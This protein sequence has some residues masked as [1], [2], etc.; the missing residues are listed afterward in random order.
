VLKNMNDFDF[1]SSLYD[2]D[3][4]IL[5]GLNKEQIKAV[6]M[7][8]GPLLIQAGAGSG[9]TKTLTHRVAYI[10]SQ[11]KARSDE[12]LAV[13]F[14]NKAAQE[15]RQRV[16]RLLNENS[17]NRYFMPYMGT[18]HAIC[19]KLLRLEAELIGMSRSFV[20]F[21][22]ADRLA[23]VKRVIKELKIDEKTFSPKSIA[24][25]ISSAKNELL[26]AD[27]YLA[28]VNS[29]LTEVA[30]RV[31]PLYTK[32]LRQANGF[33]FDDL[34]NEVVRLFNTNTLVR[35]KWQQHFKYIMV[36]EYQD[37]NEAQYRLIRLL[38]NDQQNLAVIGDDWQTIFSW[39]G[40]NYR[41]ILNFE[42]DYPNCHVI[43]LEQN[44]RST[45]NI[46]AAGQAVITKNVDRSDKKLW[47]NSSDGLPVQVLQI[48]DERAE[49][50]TI[51]LKI[52]NDVSSQTRNY[53][54]FAILYRTNSQSRSLEESLIRYGLPYKVVGGQRFYDRKE[55]K[56]IIAYLRLIYQ[57]D[58]FISFD[59]IYNVPSRGIGRKSYSLFTQ[60]LRDNQFSL[61]E[62]L[63]NINQCS[64][65]STKALNGLRDIADILINFQTVVN[66]LSPDQIIDKLIKR[67]SYLSY[68]DDGTPQ[69]EAKQEN[70]K[71]ML[72]VAKSF[73]YYNLADFLE[74]ISLVSDLD[75]VD[76][77]ANAV[78]MM[79][80]HAAKGLE[81]PVVFIP[82]MEETIF[83]HSR[84]LYDA[85]QM[86]E[87]R[88]LC[89]V[90]ITRAREELYLLA[91]NTRLI[92]GSVQHNIP[93][94]F[95]NEID[96]TVVSA[97]QQNSNIF[98]SG[99]LNKLAQDTIYIPDL[100]LGD[101]V[102]HQLFGEGTVTELEGTIATVYFN[103]RGVRKL[104]IS[105]A[106]IKK[107]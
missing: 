64:S 11:N 57:N 27:D 48:N 35:Q 90:G 6:T 62:G 84:S 32:E 9:K 105:F 69:G 93:S 103:T 20:I 28:R 52:A 36:D 67:L 73:Q 16:A 37:T 77:S 72:S 87:E 14:T 60:W 26:D 38:T 3:N 24:N 47:T 104:D 40:A 51:S 85:Q 44:Y 79:T 101:A 99:E 97:M 59:R 33:D 19:V 55:I 76:L 88:R 45:K 56:D 94:R 49:A 10:L 5:D 74:E 29:P 2:A 13:T 58:D 50:D 71:E 92:F 12:I 31:Y 83:P 102:S 41:N 107:L 42:R 46:L 61:Y 4:K 70:V 78:T 1:G 21:D 96:A 30:A 98:G 18:F 65:L 53:A 91:A 8:E 34:I 17:A 106:P 81:F 39:R 68:L 23:A 86:E 75:S 89:Y 54:D 22:E 7:T 80:I 43:K 100:T 25:L 63:M 15:M 95:L 66:E 82:G